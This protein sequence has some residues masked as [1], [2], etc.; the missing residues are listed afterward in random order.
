MCGSEENL[1]KAEI[2][3]TELN[4]C[5]NCGKFGKILGPIEEKI[6]P[7][8]KGKGIEKLD[9]GPDREVLLVITEDYAE[10]IKKKRESLGLKQKDFAKKINEKE[11]VIHKIETGSLEPSLHLAR[12][13]ERFLK[14]KLVEQHEEEIKER[15]RQTK[16]EG[17]TLGDFI[18]VKKK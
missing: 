9:T 15:S 1:F 7:T 2:E 3:G 17:F 4:V 8:K 16:S 5:E 18:S 6:I 11:S 10:L 13:I 12:K 14:I